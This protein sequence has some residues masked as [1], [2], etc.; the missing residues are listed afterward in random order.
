MAL[1]ASSPRVARRRRAREP[2]GPGGAARRRLRGGHTAES[3]AGA[4]ALVDKGPP[5]AGGDQRSAHAR[6]DRHR[7]ARPSSSRR[8]PQTV[9]MM[10]TAYS[11]LGPIIAAVNEGSVYRFFL[12]PWN[13]DEMRSAV[14]GRDVAARGA[15]RPAASWSTCWAAA[16][17]SSRP[18]WSTSSALQG[19]L[20]A[21]ERMSTVGR[22][23]AGIAH[24]IRNSLTVMMNLLEL[25]QQNPAE[26]A[27]A[28]PP[29]SG[30]SRP[31]TRLLRL[32]NDVNSLARGQPAQRSPVRRSRWSPSW[33]SCWPPSASDPLRQ[34]IARSPSARPQRAGAGAG[35]RPHPP[36]LLAL[37]RSVAQA[38]R[39][40]DAPIE[41]VRAIPSK[42]RAPASRCC[43]PPRG[44]WPRPAGTRRR[45]PGS[46]RLRPDL[47][48]DR[49]G[50]GDQPGGGRRPRRP[51]GACAR[52]PS[53][54]RPRSSCG[55][56]MPIPRWRHHEPARARLARAGIA[57]A[58]C[59]QPLQICAGPGAEAAGASS[60]WP[61]SLLAGAQLFTFERGPPAGPAR[62]DHPGARAAGDLRGP[63]REKLLD[64]AQ[65]ARPG[66]PVLYG[67]TGNRE[68]LMDAINTWRVFR[69]VPEG[70]RPVMLADAIRKAQETL[71]LEC[72]LELAAAELRTDTDRLEDAL[73]ELR[74]SQET[75]PPRRAPGH[76][77]PHHQE[78]DPGHRLPPGCPAGL[79]RPGGRG[80]EPARRP[81]G[82]AA[83]L[84]LHRHPLAARHAGRDPRLRR[85]P[86]RGV[87]ASSRS[88]STRWSASRSPSAATTR[89]PASARWCADLRSRGPH[90]R[91][92]PSACTRCIINLVRNAFQAT[93]EGGDVTVRTTADERAR[94]SSRSRTPATPSPPTSRPACSSRS[95]PPRATRA[96]AWACPCAG[97]P[98]NATAASSPA[99]AAPVSRT[100]FRI[101]LPRL[102]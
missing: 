84:R 38:T 27:R 40:P 24:N 55:S 36:G 81:P 51:S 80:R 62:S 83:G 69:V 15:G 10:L 58:P 78:P 1:A 9:R 97:P 12:K 68:I 99:A 56:R 47:R 71:E 87:P 30:P 11:D 41:L 13:P 16:R 45:P 34:A 72:S 57:P 101:R 95:S 35:S 37:L 67:G 65:A 44:S 60:C 49:A 64:L 77:G 76:P 92:T 48:P 59:P 70:P 19:E 100:R 85:E 3:G 33:T 39:R 31:W 28:A 50:P 63:Q 2:R 46:R 53:N 88:S 29:P 4:L 25:V 94:R 93:P 75:H 32:V 23:S 42:D 22:F 74:E 89:W 5:F 61:R 17:A 14:A 26:Q 21:A 91:S 54:A 20:L 6:H 43:S 90:S 7:A 52:V 98:S 66:R 8:T 18:P 79:Q 96:W 86:A 73:A 82:R 102:G